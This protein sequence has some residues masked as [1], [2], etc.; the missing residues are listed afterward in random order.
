MKKK[1]IALLAGAL[2][3]LSAGS[4]FASFGD[5][6]LIRVFYDRNGAEIATDLGSVTS[7]T[8]AGT[9]T[10]KDGSFGSLTT[11]YA[12][13]FAINHATNE[14]WATGSNTTASLI[15]GTSGGMTTLKSG[16]TSMFG[17]YNTQGGTNYAGL[18]SAINS[19]KNKVS[20]VQGNM[21]NAINNTYR[22]NTEASLASI[23]GVNGA[24]TTQT[25][26]YWANGNTTVASEKIGTAVATITT[27]SFGKTTVTA[28]TPI[29]AA[30]WLLGSGILGLFGIRRKMNA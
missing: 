5:M 1:I 11:G 23:I 2:M 26:Y 30:A 15:N 7:L 19:Y 25:L 20:A 3:A 13:Y 9:I 4:A 27:D 8:A 29:P 10:S 16:T 21:S 22:L 14:L 17:T 12:V 28:N 6:E 24:S 18:A